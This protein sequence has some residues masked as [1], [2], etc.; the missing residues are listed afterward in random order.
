[1]SSAQPGC[2]HGLNG[3]LAMGYHIHGLGQKQKAGAN[4]HASLRKSLAPALK[5]LALEYFD[6]I[7][8]F[9]IPTV[10]DDPVA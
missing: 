8:G 9:T 7:L 5:A 10:G 3:L 4:N 1:M 6:Y 2:L